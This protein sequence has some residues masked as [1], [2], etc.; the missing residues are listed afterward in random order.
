[1]DA[2]SVPKV[3]RFS[4]LILIVLMLFSLASCNS[5]RNSAFTNLDKLVASRAYDDALAELDSKAIQQTYTDKDKVIRALD[6]GVLNYLAAKPQVSNKSFDEAE[7]L[8]EEY[9][10]KSISSAAASFI[11]N[12]NALEY[13]GEPYE[14][15]YLNVFKALNYAGQKDMDN[16]FVEIRRVG[17]KLTL[18]EDKYRKMADGMNSSPDAKSKVSVGKTEFYNSAL[19]HYLSAVLYRADRKADDASIDLQK[20]SDAF[21]E[22]AHVYTFAEPKFDNFLSKTDKARVSLVSL[23]G[24]GPYK[25]AHTYR[26]ETASNSI[27]ISAED[28]D[29]SGDMQTQAAVTLYFPGVEGGLNFKCQVPYVAAKQSEIKRIVLL[30]DGNQAGAFSKLED[31]NQVAL[32]T[33]KLREN[34][35]YVKTI[36]RT[37]VKGIA[38]K[39]AKDQVGKVST[40]NGIADLL[41]HG[42]VNLGADAAVDA[43]EQADLRCAR[44][45]P[46][47]VWVG[48]FEMDGGAHKLT[49]QYF[50]GAGKLLY[51]DEMGEK[52]VDQKGLNLWSSWAAL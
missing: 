19:A 26:L 43:S 45:F 12:D 38:A 10:T 27:S 13:A 40:G 29:S 18:L 25:K 34:L 31:I 37:V 20:I 49:V 24:Q 46:G 6:Y 1:M 8:I 17:E 39:V 7:S 3:A 11:L 32:E 2:H 5:T 36:I 35:V 21:K 16:S 48:D 15:L 23:V 14:D 50:N 42:A 30:V 4:G 41:L 51:S 52:Q 28:E 47:E 22:E 9:Y 44:Y 33:F